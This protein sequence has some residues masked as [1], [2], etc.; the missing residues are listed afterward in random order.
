MKLLIENGRLINPATATDEVLN[1]LVEEGKIK[2]ISKTKIIEEA[3]KYIDADGCWVVPGLIDLHVHFREPGFTHKETI[4]TGSLSG[5]MGGFTTV[6]AMP[7]TKPAIDSPQRVQELLAKRQEAGVIKILPIGSI[8][9]SQA[10]EELVDILALKK[11]GICG[12]SEDGKTVMEEKLMKW[13]MDRAKEENLPILVHCEN[14]KL[15]AGGVM[16]K[17]KLAETLGLEGIPPE[18]EDSITKRD[19]QLAQQVGARLHICHVSTKGAV[20]LIRMA[21]I[22]GTKVTA[23]VC[24]HHFTLTEETVGHGDPNA[25]MNPPLRGKEDVEAILEGLKDNTIEMI[26]TDHAPHHEDEK[27]LGF[28]D[29]PFGIVGLETALSLSITELVQKGTLTPLQL[30]EKLSYNPARL[31]GLETGDLS[32]GK[33]ADITII[34]PR[35]EYTIDKEKFYSKGKNTPFH[36]RRVKGRVMYTIVDGRIV[37]DKGRLIPEL[38]EKYKEYR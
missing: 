1:L 17:G 30:I 22:K 31:L 35:M 3:E 33:T 4:F 18:A 20:D 27:A 6:C 23:E 37:V 9:K 32:E 12:I 2:K 38:E 14:H 7:N 25:K 19:I 5:V 36:G 29:A 15:V 24:P 28:K 10:G 13:A 8:T 34:D 26:A 16:N 11:A 21:K